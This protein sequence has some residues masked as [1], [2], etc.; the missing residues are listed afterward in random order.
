MQL[1]HFTGTNY[2][3]MFSNHSG[4]ARHAQ[5]E[6]Q[7]LGKSYTQPHAIV[8]MNARTHARTRLLAHYEIKVT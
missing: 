8:H 4:M 1:G 7:N 6:H 2:M 5:R 3:Y